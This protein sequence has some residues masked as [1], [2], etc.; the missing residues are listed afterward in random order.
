MDYRAS[1]S[2]GSSVSSAST[3]STPHLGRSVA[4]LHISGAPSHASGIAFRGSISSAFAPG[5]AIYG[6]P[7]SSSHPTSAS[8]EYPQV[9]LMV[10]SMFDSC[11]V[12]L[13]DMAA[14]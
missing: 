8:E 3:P 14:E 10:E 13:N 2:V 7:E 5:T 6:S 4:V 11:A 9:R 1:F 12:S